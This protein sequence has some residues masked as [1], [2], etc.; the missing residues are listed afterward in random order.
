MTEYDVTL[1]FACK[2]NVAYLMQL[3]DRLVTESEVIGV[4]DSLTR[5]VIMKVENHQEN[6]LDEY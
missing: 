1:R 2:E 6:Y 5:V 3:I 4:K